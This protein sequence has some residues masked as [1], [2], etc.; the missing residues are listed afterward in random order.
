MRGRHVCLSSRPD[1]GAWGGSHAGVSRGCAESGGGRGILW[2]LR[3]WSG[4][5]M[6]PITRVSLPQRGHTRGSGLGSARVP[7]RRTPS[8]RSSRLRSARA[9]RVPLGHV[10]D[11]VGAG[12]EAQS[13]EAHRGSHHVADEC[14]ELAPIAGMYEDPVVHGEA[15]S[16]PRIQRIDPLLA[17]HDLSICGRGAG[18]GLRRYQDS[19][20]RQSMSDARRYVANSVCRL[21]ALPL[22]SLPSRAYLPAR[23]PAGE[24]GHG[25]GNGRAG[26]SGSLG[27]WGF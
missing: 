9:R 5:G 12:G 23:R 13:G 15:A 7:G 16:S 4:C 1:C 20:R 11:L 6:K 17:Q 8:R 10:D 14:L 2:R 27:R 24:R 18:V 25:D 19:Q 22:T 26:G 21:R 3:R